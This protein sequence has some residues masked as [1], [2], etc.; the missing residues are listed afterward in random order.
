M[1]ILWLESIGFA[2]AGRRE[3][4]RMVTEKV[5]ALC[6]GFL[7]A[8][9]ELMQTGFAVGQA[10]MSGASPVAAA[11]R[12]TKR[13]AS[14]AIAPSTRRVRSNFRRLSSRD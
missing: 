13:I 7:A 1:P 6:Q 9:M 4:E 3:S 10:L 14:A 2:P 5:D 8:Q 12:G 11:I